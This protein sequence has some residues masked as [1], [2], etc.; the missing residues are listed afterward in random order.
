MNKL[1]V[2]ANYRS[3]FTNV[4]AI[5]NTHEGRKLMMDW[6]SIAMSGYI[7]CHGFDQAA[8]QYLIL[9][10]ASGDKYFQSIRPFNFSC[11]YNDT[12]RMVSRVHRSRVVF[13]IL[14]N[15]TMKYVRMIEWL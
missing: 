5:R 14:P 3:A 9:Q 15:V 8:L 4:V 11:L 12:G 10:Q 7:Q 2:L 1:I 6:I 13:P